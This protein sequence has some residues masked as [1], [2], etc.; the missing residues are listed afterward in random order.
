MV[1]RQLHRSPEEG[2]LTASGGSAVIE[3]VNVPPVVESIGRSRRFTFGT[4]A[5]TLASLQSLVQTAEVPDLTL[6]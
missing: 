3:F 6:F 5:A 1:V 2:L 4:K